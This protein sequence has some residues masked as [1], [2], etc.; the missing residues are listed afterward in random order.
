MNQSSSSSAFSAAPVVQLARSP[1]RLIVEERAASWRKIVLDRLQSLVRLED[2]WDGYS[3][4]PVNLA[5]ANFAIRVLEAVCST[6]T[7]P[8]QIVPGSAG[9]LQIEWHFAQG[10]VELHVRAPNDVV[11]WLRDANTG[12]DGIELQLA[13]NFIDVAKWIERL[14]QPGATAAAA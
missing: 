1:A 10:D 11:A 14:E 9:D 3:G 2:G 13:N 7:C 12:D 4:Q 5:N 6:E 8:P